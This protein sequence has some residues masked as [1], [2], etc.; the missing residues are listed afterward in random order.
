M[1]AGGFYNGKPWAHYRCLLGK[2]S[3]GELAV[4]IT[5]KDEPSGFVL[6]RLRSDSI[7]GLVNRIVSD[8]MLGEFEP[9]YVHRNFLDDKIAQTREHLYALMQGEFAD[10]KGW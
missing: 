1:R 6:A 10:R 8:W 3:S 5:D 2:L 9:I 4:S 7:E